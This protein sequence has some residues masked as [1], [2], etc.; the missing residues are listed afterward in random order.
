[1][2]AMTDAMKKAKNGNDL[3]KFFARTTI[4]QH[5]KV[6]NFSE[7]QMKEMFKAGGLDMDSKQEQQEKTNTT[8]TYSPQHVQP[9]LLSESSEI[10]FDSAYLADL[11]S[12]QQE[13]THSP[14]QEDDEQQKNTETRGVRPFYPN[15]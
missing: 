10:D 2:Q 6:I 15:E 9:N 13:N 11:D 4:M 1:M 14:Q 8:D 12:P 5:A 3:E 7:E